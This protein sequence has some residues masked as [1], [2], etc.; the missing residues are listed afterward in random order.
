MV[1]VDLK[2]RFVFQQQGQ[3]DQ[4]QSGKKLS[5]TQRAALDAKYVLWS[6]IVTVKKNPIFS[7]M[8]SFEHSSGFWKEGIAEILPKY[9]VGGVYEDCPIINM[10][11]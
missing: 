8:Y 10:I 11:K 9:F 1:F 6:L 5:E 7:I 4:E 2:C 3:L